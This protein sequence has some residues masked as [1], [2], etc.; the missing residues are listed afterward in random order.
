VLLLHR[1]LLLLLRGV[2]AKVGFSR[3][4][5]VCLRPLARGA[6][7]RSAASPVALGYAS[8]VRS[9]S[10]GADDEDP[11]VHGAGRK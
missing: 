2:R 4:K 8:T 3:I 7:I 5:L 9:R 1:L 10:D 11:P 6:V